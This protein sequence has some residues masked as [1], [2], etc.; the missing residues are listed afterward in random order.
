MTPANTHRNPRGPL[1]L[2]YLLVESKV[3]HRLDGAEVDFPRHGTQ[4]EYLDRHL[5]LV[6][7]VR[8]GE[9]LVLLPDDLT[10]VRIPQYHPVAA[11]SDER[12]LK[13]YRETHQSLLCSCCITYI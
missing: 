12:R 6:L 9:V 2:A 10:R 3:F 11:N 4:A 13:S 5:R 8:A 7:D 1:L